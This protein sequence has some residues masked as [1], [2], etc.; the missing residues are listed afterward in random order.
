MYFDLE[1]I[2]TNIVSEHLAG[3]TFDEL[4]KKHFL[5]SPRQASLIYM[6]KTG[7]N[8]SMIANQI[9]SVEYDRLNKLQ[10]AYWTEARSGD[11][12]A[13]KAYL[14]ISKSKGEL[15]EKMAMVPNLDTNELAQ[16]ILDQEEDI[17][18]MG[19]DLKRQFDLMN[20]LAK[21]IKWPEEDY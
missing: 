20:T 10:S 1:A 7:Q 14:A 19:I 5:A 15:M 13:L 9:I 4:A 12:K 6:W 18:A 17:K 16:I 8:P 3:K 21:D 2:A 11:E